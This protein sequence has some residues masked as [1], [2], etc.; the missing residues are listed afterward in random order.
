MSLLKAVVTNVSQYIPLEFLQQV[1]ID[2]D[3][4]ELLA[5]GKIT[6][7]RDKDR[8]ALKP[9]F[10]ISGTPEDPVF[11]QLQNPMT[12]S[13][14]GT[15]F[16]DNSGQDINVYTYPWDDVGNPDYYYVTVTSAPKP[17]YPDGVPQFTREHIPYI[18][19]NVVPDVKQV[20]NFIPNGQFLLHRDLPDSGLINSTGFFPIAYGGWSFYCLTSAPG[21]TTNFVTFD[22]FNSP[23]NNP[24][25]N[26]RFAAVVQCTIPNV[27]DSNK[28]LAV[29]FDD[30]NYL[31]GQEITLK[32]SAYSKDGSNHNATLFWHQYFGSGGSSIV[33]TEIATFTVT[34]SI[35]SFIFNFT[36]PATIGKVLGTG[37]DDA[38]AIFIQS[39]LSTVSFIGFT[40]ILGAEGTF[41]SLSYPNQSPEQTKALAF[42]ASM[43]I[44]AFDGSD[45]NKFI[46]IEPPASGGADSRGLKFKYSTVIATAQISLDHDVS[47]V[48]G[49]FAQTLI[50]FNVVDFSDN[51]STDIDNNRIV[52]N[53]SG[54]YEIK[55]PISLGISG[56]GNFYG[57]AIYITIN[58]GSNIEIYRSPSLPITNAVGSLNGFGNFC[59]IFNQSFNANDHLNAYIS[60]FK[61]SG[62]IVATI[63]PEI[64]TC[65]S[66][67]YITP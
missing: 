2:K 13:S 59:A 28:D 5:Y 15:L 20:D 66:V 19:D 47:I 14:I 1:F 45:E 41:S 27:S 25:A 17:G 49:P 36:V 37:N 57:I 52:I 51:V 21:A 4:G 33:D 65:M 39:P 54:I 9:I 7:Y 24:E 30:V 35:Q 53:R 22:R 12:L 64:Q 55:I 43:P 23:I 62:S 26:P 56:T 6:F 38:S 61:D 34:P 50:P 32:L 60:Y 67:R 44:P 42:P 11:V 16:D 8:I 63:G 58:D 18:P 3:T 46:Q 29:H 10:K 40:D 31:Q 48:E